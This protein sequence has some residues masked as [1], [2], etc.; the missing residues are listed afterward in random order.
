MISRINCLK[1]IG[2]G[3][4]K[5]KIIDLEEKDEVNHRHFASGL[6]KNRKRMV[7]PPPISAFLSL[8]TES[9]KFLAIYLPIRLN[10]G[11]GHQSGSREPSAGVDMKGPGD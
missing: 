5:Y 2:E 11:R 3:V 4:K 10:P 1:R 8:D 6:L 7:R 9:I